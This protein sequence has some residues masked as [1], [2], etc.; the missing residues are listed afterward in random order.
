MSS[1]SC[2]RFERVANFLAFPLNRTYRNPSKPP[3]RPIELSG[4]HMRKTFPILVTLF[5]VSVGLT[6]SASNTL[7]AD[8]ARNHIG[9]TAT[10]CGV[11][12]SNSL[13]RSDQRLSSTLDNP[14]PNQV[15]TILIWG[16]DLAKFSPKPSAWEGKRICAA[17]RDQFVS[18]VAGDCGEVAGAGHGSLKREAGRFCYSLLVAVKSFQPTRKTRTGLISPQAL[19]FRLPSQHGGSIENASLRGFC[20]SGPLRK[21]S[22]VGGKHL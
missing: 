11:V 22:Q 4:G 10:V 2:V 7:T 14:Y 16:D 8:E 9:Q 17:G 3:I 13:G 15:F 5:I 19:W 6:A 1:T 12:A 18:R 21:P 20:T